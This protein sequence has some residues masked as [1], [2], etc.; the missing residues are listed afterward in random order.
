[1]AA[2][3]TNE[4]KSDTSSGELFERYAKK[5]YKEPEPTALAWAII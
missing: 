2:S 1:M 4:M 5:A 3:R